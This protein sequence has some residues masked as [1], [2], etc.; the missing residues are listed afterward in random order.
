MGTPPVVGLDLSITATGAVFYGDPP[1]TITPAKGVVGDGRL[2]SVRDQVMRRVAPSMAPLVV[3]EGPVLRSQAALALG[4]LHGVIRAALMDEGIPYALVPPATLKKYAT[5][6]VN[7]GKPEM[8]V[9]LYKRAGLELGDD[10][11]VDAWWL[12]AMGLDALG[13]PLVDLPAA[14]REAMDKVEWPA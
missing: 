11:Q 1:T 8:A 10:N 9:A 12:R 14:Q 7:A 13:A 6:K 3:I 4:L 5:G 2:T